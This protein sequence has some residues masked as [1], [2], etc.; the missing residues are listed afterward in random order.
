MV[1]DGRQADASSAKARRAHRLH[2]GRANHP[3][4]RRVYF[5]RRLT[6][7]RAEER[8]GELEELDDELDE[9]HETPLEERRPRETSHR[10]RRSILDPDQ[11]SDEESGR[12]LQLDPETGRRSDD[13]R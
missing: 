2:L 3:A 1:T 10:P 9:R 12:P 4:F 13:S 6:M 5:A 7:D 11:R 8:R